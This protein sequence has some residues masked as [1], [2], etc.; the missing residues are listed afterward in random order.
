MFI[1]A[2]DE[3]DETEVRDVLDFIDGL[4]QHMRTFHA[5]FACRHYPNVTLQFGEE[6]VVESSKAHTLDIT[7][8]IESRLHVRLESQRA[9][10]A[11]SLVHKSQ[12]VF[13]WVVLVVRS[14]NE[15]HDRGENDAQLLASVSAVPG[16]LESLISNI[17][18]R[19]WA[20]GSFP[21]PDPVIDF[22][23]NRYV[24]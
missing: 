5:C 9:A 20:F 7:R 4:T 15:Q 3:L 17:L 1:D 16:A 12:G 13:L 6:L 24:V 21:F 23:R 8:Y 11:K 14:I 19:K 2:I 18:C 22:G 10:L